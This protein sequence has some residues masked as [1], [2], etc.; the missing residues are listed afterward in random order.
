MLHRILTEEI[1]AMKP[2]SA[3]V[4]C[5]LV[6]YHDIIGDIIWKDRRVKELID[7]VE[8]ERDLYMLIALGKADMRAIRPAWSNDKKI[9]EIRN[10]VM[11]ALESE[12]PDE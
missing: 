9:E 12:A 2:R 11:D 10:L 6:C 5:K 4:I 3:K 8:D 7:I 1:E